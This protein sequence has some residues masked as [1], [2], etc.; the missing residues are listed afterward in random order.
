MRTIGN[1]EIII[2]FATFL[3]CC[4]TNNQLC[5][6]ISC[7]V[8][9]L[10]PLISCQAY[11]KVVLPTHWPLCCTNLYKTIPPLT[12]FLFQQVLSFSVDSRSY[13]QHGSCWIKGITCPFRFN[14]IINWK[15]WWGRACRWYQIYILWHFKLAMACIWWKTSI[16]FYQR[17]VLLLCLLL[18]L[19]RLTGMF[20][21][22][23]SLVKIDHTD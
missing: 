3:C 9:E 14:I 17:K 23:S 20:T 2:S 21:S 7:Q 10:R 1:S 13:Y 4:S 12:F 8:F 15:S 5:F 18:G 16:G 11:P 19:I 22:T 6:T